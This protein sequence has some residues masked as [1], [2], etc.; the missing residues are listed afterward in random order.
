MA[1]FQ[2][3]GPVQNA[4]AVTETALGL[5]AA[6]DRLNRE[7]KTRSIEGLMGISS[8][9]PQGRDQCCSVVQSEAHACREA[10]EDGRLIRGS[11]SIEV[12]QRQ[13]PTSSPFPTLPK[14]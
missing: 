4:T 14:P 3:P 6:T 1:V 10:T 12:A 5:L 11:E 9:L 2:Q 13:S 8:G 7:S